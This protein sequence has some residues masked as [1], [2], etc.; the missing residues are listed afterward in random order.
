MSPL[1]LR[2]YRAER[3][4]REEFEGLRGRVLASVRGRLR[5]SGVRLD[6]SD[7]EA[8]YSQAW[9]GL[10]TAML[11]GRQIENPAGWLVLVTSR[12]AIDEHRAR[13]RM[14]GEGAVASPAVGEGARSAAAVAERAAPA[15]DHAEALDDRVKMR[16]LMEGL[17]ARL[18]A[19]EREAAALCYLQGLSRAQAAARMGLSEA[20]MRKLMEGRSRGRPGVAAKVGAIVETISSGRW[21]DEQ[22]SLMR[23]FAF[24]VL[25][26][27]GERYR[28]AEAHR[29]QCPACRRYVRSLRGLAGVLPPVLSP[30]ALT[31]GAI[32]GSG[33]GV[34]SGG[35][36]AAAKGAGAGA[37]GGAASA[38]GGGWSAGGASL[39]GGASA[40]GGAA[41][42]GGGWLVLGGGLGAKLAAACLLALGIGAGCVAL[43]VGGGRARE[44]RHAPLRS[45]SLPA[46]RSPLPT[47]PRAAPALHSPSAAATERRS[48]ASSVAKPSGATREFSP[49]QPSGQG[50]RTARPAVAPAGAAGEPAQRGSSSARPRTRPKAG[51]GG[52]GAAAEREFSPG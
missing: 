9:Q 42:A 15:R 49:E 32:G 19:R 52:T 40:A 43:G 12:R 41:S 2:R 46:A 3:L 34:S 44:G 10:Y 6:E 31:A 22:G 27:E 45:P 18:S 4:L 37:S 47:S 11:D 21:C 5:A 24:G 38:A 28:L 50:V 29:R 25:D 36:L 51:G 8:C 30:L 39:A 13:R 16:Q 17:R 33:A 7:L 48:P 20:R 23:A 1:G 26:P 35:A 14:G